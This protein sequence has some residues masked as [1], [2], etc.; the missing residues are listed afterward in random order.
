MVMCGA[1]IG[2]CS[3]LINKSTILEQSEK[4]LTTYFEKTLIHT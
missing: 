3:I 4:T 1:L 2:V